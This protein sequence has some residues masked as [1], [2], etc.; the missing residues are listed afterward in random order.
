MM[1]DTL[2]GLFWIFI[3]LLDGFDCFAS[4]GWSLVLRNRND[5]AAN[6]SA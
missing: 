5:T 2:Y 6:N 1:V 4:G 3:E